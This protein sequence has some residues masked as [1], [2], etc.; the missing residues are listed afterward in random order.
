MILLQCIK[1]FFDGSG[2]DLIA[3]GGQMDPVVEET[4]VS[5]RQTLV[6]KGTGHV[7]K[8]IT[9]SLCRLT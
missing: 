2:P 1:M 5:H 4:G 8:T 6:G 3:T 9:A 7:E